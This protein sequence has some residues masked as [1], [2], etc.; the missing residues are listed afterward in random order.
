[1]EVV[2]HEFGFNSNNHFG[3]GASWGNPK[4]AT[5]QK[6]G[7]WAK[8]RGWSSSDNCPDPVIAKGHLD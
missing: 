4:L 5:Q 6:L 8:R 1:M 2:C 7:L 3:A